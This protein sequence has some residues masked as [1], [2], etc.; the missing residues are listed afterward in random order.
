[1]Y[2]FIETNVSGYG[3]TKWCEFD[4][5]VISGI[6]AGKKYPKKIIDL[7]PNFPDERFIKI[8]EQGT[9]EA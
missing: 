2:N 7:L 3:A 1:M 6:L 4:A 5:E 9:R 8:K